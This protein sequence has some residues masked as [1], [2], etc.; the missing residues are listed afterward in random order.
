MSTTTETR[1]Q[2]NNNP[3]NIRLGQTWQGLAPTQPDP[4]FCTFVDAE[5]GIRAL[6]LILLNYQRIDSLKTV[7]Q[8]INRWAPPADHND[9]SAYVSFV[10]G[11]MGVDPDAGV[12]MMDPTTLRAC[13]AAIIAQECAGYAY[14]D[15]V[16]TAAMGMAGV[17]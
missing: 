3:G 17:A 12:S 14:A 10:A 9:T 7:R 11:R 4:D 1:G 8:M 13:A 16:V 6:C 2:R 15:G 5:H